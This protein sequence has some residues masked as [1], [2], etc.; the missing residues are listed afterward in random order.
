MAV[1]KGNTAVVTGS[2]GGIGLATAKQLALQ[3]LNIVLADRDAGLLKQARTAVEGIGRGGKVHAVEMDVS[4]IEE[5]ENLRNEAVK[6]FGSV[7]VVM[8]NSGIGGR[9]SLTDPSTYPHFQEI[10]NV[11]INGVVNGLHVFVPVLLKNPRPSMI[12]AT[13]SKQGIT[14]PPGNPAY[15]ASKA[16][17]RSLMESLAHELRQTSASVSAH[18]LIPGWTHTGL[19]SRGNEAGPKPDGAWSADQVAEKLIQDLAQGRFYILCPD[20]QVT[21][22]IDHK[23]ILYN[24]NDIVHHRS[25]LSRWD[26]KY[27]VDF[28]TWMEA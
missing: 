14:N 7:E 11:N 16:V 12:I 2:G 18:L 21:E 17:V 3:G 10:F 27:E 26:P 22:E 19:T 28:K 9:T 5:M 1:V 13:G 25:G 6:V 15:N 24:A 4:S 20:N 23:R 8:L